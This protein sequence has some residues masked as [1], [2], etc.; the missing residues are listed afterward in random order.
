MD[1]IIDRFKMD[2]TVLLKL[3][4][5]IRSVC[6]SHWEAVLH[7]PKWDLTYEEASNLTHALIADIQGTTV[8]TK[9]LP[10]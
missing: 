9:V 4:Q 3:H 10:T 6:S 7:S 2:D 5:L 8:I 1:T